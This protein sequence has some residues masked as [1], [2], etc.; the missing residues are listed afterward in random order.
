MSALTYHSVEGRCFH[1]LDREYCPL[2][3]PLALQS[4]KICWA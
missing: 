4:I 3:V 1:A 2:Y